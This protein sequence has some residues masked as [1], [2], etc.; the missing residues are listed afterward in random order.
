MSEKD[1]SSKVFFIITITDRIAYTAV[2]V[3]PVVEYWLE[4]EIV[5]RD[6]SNKTSHHETDDESVRCN[7]ENKNNL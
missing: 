5:Q 2:F 6:R 3:T 4:R 1:F 7:G